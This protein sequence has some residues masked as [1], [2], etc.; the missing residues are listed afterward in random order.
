MKIFLDKFQLRESLENTI[1][2]LG[3]FSNDRKIE[4]VLLIDS[5][6][7]DVVISDSSRLS[8]I[9]TNLTNNAIKFT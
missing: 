4:L 1:S 7:P 5:D 6:V 8:Q 2:M 3:Q 9:V